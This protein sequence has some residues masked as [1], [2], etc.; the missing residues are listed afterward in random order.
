MTPALA[1]L[2]DNDSVAS[3]VCRAAQMELGD[4]WKLWEPETI[5]KELHHRGVDVPV[6]NRQQLMAG[7]NLL[8]TG[9]VFYDALVFDRT[10]TAFS[11]DVCDCECFDDAAVAQHAWCVDEI[12]E[13]LEWANEPFPGFDREPVALIVRSLMVEGF[14][15]TPTALDFVE[16]E[17]DRAWAGKGRELKQQVN[18]L[19]ADA[20][21]LS[22]RNIPYPETPSGVQMA[23]LASVK[24]FLM[25]RRSLRTTQRAK[26]TA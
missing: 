19:W 2:K 8:L 4:S 24:A 17:L 23:R 21:G 15:L 22:V 16:E 26:L 7:R 6:G 5:W 20:K 1:A 11:N 25:E 9:R 3:V 14:V 18:E 13:I 10:S 12:K